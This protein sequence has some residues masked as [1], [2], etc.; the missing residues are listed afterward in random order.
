MVTTRDE[1][2]PPDASSVQSRT[3]WTIVLLL[4]STLTVMAGATISPVLPGL[5]DEFS[6]TPGSATLVPLLLS[7]PALAIAICAPIVGALIDR[8][9]RRPVL[10]VAVALYGIAG[11]SGLVIG[12]LW[13]LLAGRVAL[14]VAVAGI[15]VTATALVAD[16][17]DGERRSQVLGRQAASIGFGGT[18]FLCLGGLLGSL[19]TRGPFAIYLLA[20]ALLP[21]VQRVIDEPARH[22]SRGPA[23]AGAGKDGLR[24]SRRLLAVVYAAGLLGRLSSY[25]IPTR[26]PF[27]LETLVGAGPTVSGLSVALNTLAGAAVSLSYGRIRARL[28]LGSLAVATAVLLGAGLV[29][30]GLAG[31]LPLVLVGQFGSPLLSSPIAQASGS[32]T[33]F[34]TAGGL[35]LAGGVA[36]VVVLASRRRREALQA[37]GPPARRN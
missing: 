14:G 12:D 21:F 31:G 33:V 32:S 17:F 8:V 27:L 10:L 11:G 19:D 5:A 30:I 16:Y 13:A 28:G 1:S 35:A 20:L 26:L 22:A 25:T 18:V 37:S 36:L 34:T 6:T 2:G 24:D 29:T 9:G 15:M 23:G 4:V 3:S 7:A